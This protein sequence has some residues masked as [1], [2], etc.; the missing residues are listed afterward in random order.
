MKKHKQIWAEQFQQRALGVIFVGVVGVIAMSIALQP[1]A[2]AWGIGGL[3]V[4]ILLG[5]ALG[6]TVYPRVETQCQQGAGWIKQR[7]LRWGIMLYG[8]RLTLQQVSDVGASALLIDVLTLSTTFFL[9]CWLGMRVLGLSRESTWLIGAGSSICGAAAIAA[10]E[11]VLKAKGEQVAV[12]VATVVVFGTLAMFLYPWM[13][14]VLPAAFE[15]A[16][17]QYGV[18]I[19]STVHEVAQVV[20]A[21]QAVSSEAGQ[22]A[23]VT[24]MLRVMMLA[25]FLI[26]LA[27]WAMRTP[28][29][30]GQT[31]ET[32]AIQIP[33]FAVVF[34]LVVGFNSLNLLP[35]ALVD[36]LVKLDE[37]LLVLAMAALGLDTRWQAVKRAGAKPLVLGASLMLWLVVGGALINYAV[38]QVI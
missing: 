8:F 14:H 6:N 27:R 35:Q 18:Y 7:F 12:A 34:L 26:L 24:K 21:G 23:V 37:V 1:Q 16:A 25:P 2:K 9:A 20:A 3:T 17:Q 10:T 30:E 11:P 36:V 38:T 28:K 32:N 15:P 22:A 31:A 19:G 4:A 33:W 13:Y 29:A 5:M